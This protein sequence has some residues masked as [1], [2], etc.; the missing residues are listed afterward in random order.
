MVHKPVCF[1]LNR[2]TIGENIP[3]PQALQLQT[4][5]EKYE[6]EALFVRPSVASNPS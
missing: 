3:Q 2:N 1:R 4:T 6:N 5:P